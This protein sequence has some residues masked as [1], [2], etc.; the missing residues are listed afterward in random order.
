MS[1]AQVNNVFPGG[2]DSEPV[3]LRAFLESPPAHLAP[4]YIVSGMR[5]ILRGQ[6]LSL[7]SLLPSPS[8]GVDCKAWTVVL[9]PS[10][11]NLPVGECGSVVVD[12]ATNKVYGHVVGSDPLGH[13]YVVPLLAVL[14]QISRCF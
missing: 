9:G 5:G 13:A 10:H 2:N 7:A 8:G 12:S 1:L 4:V 3:L 11:G 14:D 6:I